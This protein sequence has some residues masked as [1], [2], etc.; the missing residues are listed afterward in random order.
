M[1]DEPERTPESV[2]RVVWTVWV[3]AG[4]LVNLRISAISVA[5]DLRDE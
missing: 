2:I 1:T 3:I 4:V 5:I